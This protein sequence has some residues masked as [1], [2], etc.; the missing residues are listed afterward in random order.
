LLSIYINL[1]STSIII[2]KISFCHIDVKFFVITS[3]GKQE[4]GFLADDPENDI[5]QVSSSDM[6]GFMPQLLDRL[7]NGWIKSAKKFVLK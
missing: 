4:L 6:G 5:L 1:L 7:R 2:L 3:R